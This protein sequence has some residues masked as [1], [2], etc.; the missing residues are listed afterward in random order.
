MRDKVT[1]QCPQTTTFEEKGELKQIRSLTARP[2]QLT[3]DGQIYKLVI[4][5]I[6]FGQELSLDY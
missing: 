2:N 5:L 6:I 1:R 3:R 4:T